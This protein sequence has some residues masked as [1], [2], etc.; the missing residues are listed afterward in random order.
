MVDGTEIELSNLL[1]QTRDEILMHDNSIGLATF[2]SVAKAQKVLSE[3]RAFDPQA[4]L[5]VGVPGPTL[6][7][8][9]NSLLE[10]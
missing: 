6:R 1:D 8:V 5:R 3:T 2:A 4:R 10:G 9:L 7:E